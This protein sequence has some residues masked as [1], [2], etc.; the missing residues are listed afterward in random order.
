MTW[1]GYPKTALTVV[2]KDVDVFNLPFEP[3]VHIMHANTVSDGIHF[4]PLDKRSFGAASM[5]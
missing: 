3:A 4:I 1:K 5:G 2:S